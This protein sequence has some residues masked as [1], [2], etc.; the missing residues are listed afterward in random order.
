MRRRR[1]M[2]WAARINNALEDNR[3]EIFRQVCWAVAA[4]HE[5]QIVHRDLKPSN[6]MVKMDGKPKL[7]TLCFDRRTG[8]ELWR[9]KGG[10]DIPVP[11][12]VA[13]RDLVFIT[14]AHGPTIT[15]PS[16]D[17][18]FELLAGLPTADARRYA[19]LQDATKALAGARMTIA[20]FQDIVTKLAHRLDGKSAYIGIVFDDQNRFVC[21]DALLRC[22]GFRPAMEYR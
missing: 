4:A 8:R 1:E 3:F 2:Q 7:L 12:P 13:A 16:L 15:A 11:R 21:Q 19:E 9:M 17:R 18:A 20:R 22:S 10:G 6:I 5:K 14:S